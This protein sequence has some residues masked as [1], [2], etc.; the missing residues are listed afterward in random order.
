MSYQGTYLLNAVHGD[1]GSPVFND[2]NEFIGIVHAINNHIKQG[3]TFV[4]NK[5]TILKVLNEKK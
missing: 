1:S 2:E 4:I 3:L 5:E